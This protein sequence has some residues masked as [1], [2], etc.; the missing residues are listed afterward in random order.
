MLAT[1]VLIYELEW[2]VSLHLIQSWRTHYTVWYISR[3]I[4]WE[5]CIRYICIDY[6]PKYV[7]VFLRKQIFSNDSRITNIYWNRNR[8]LHSNPEH[9]D[10][11]RCLKIYSN[12][13]L[14]AC[15]TS[16]KTICYI[17]HQKVRS[18]SSIR[19]RNSY[20]ICVSKVCMSD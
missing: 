20:T 17:F 8:L 13:Y 10:F 14:F 7:L 18:I 15:N 2:R 16:A 1:N 19:S 9:F 4:F 3:Y 11:V 5:S 12:P 6:I